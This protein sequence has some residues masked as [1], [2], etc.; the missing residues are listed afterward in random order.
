MY[1]VIR[2]GKPRSIKMSKILAFIE[3]DA[4]INS[5]VDADQEYSFKLRG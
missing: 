3:T 5:V 1:I 2:F 4:Y